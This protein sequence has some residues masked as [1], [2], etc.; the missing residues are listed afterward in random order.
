MT[1]IAFP[2]AGRLP[3]GT[4]I[5]TGPPEGIATLREQGA[6]EAAGATGRYAAKDLFAVEGPGRREVT[7]ARELADQFHERW[8][9]ANPF[10]A[11]MYGIPGYDDL[12]PD[13]SPE[14]Q[15][16]WRDEAGSFGEQAA[17]LARGDV[18]PADAIT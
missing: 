7:S 4:L 15:R 1:R 10:A 12:L 2:G 11:T 14:G 16:A 13:A 3:A 9:R 18:S 17:E 5:R 6:G 8:L